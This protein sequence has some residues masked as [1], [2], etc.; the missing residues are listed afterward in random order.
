M[1]T[2][3]T[4]DDWIKQ[5]RALQQWLRHNHKKYGSRG[6]RVNRQPNG[7][8]SR[9]DAIVERDG[10]KIVLEIKC[11]KVQRNDYTTYMISKDKVDHLIEVAKGMN[12]CAG[13]LVR[14]QDHAG[15]VHFEDYQMPL[16][17]F[18]GFGGRTDR[19]GYHTDLETVY[20]IPIQRFRHIEDVPEFQR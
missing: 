8:N 12:C 5:E 17:S 2:F 18:E 6:L 11:R 10:C 14:W 19:G 16:G 9:Y 13:L 20:H 7:V 1:V 15:F 4:R 3:E